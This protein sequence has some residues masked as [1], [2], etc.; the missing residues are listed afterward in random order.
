MAVGEHGLEDAQTR[1]GEPVGSENVIDSAIA[2]S[3][4]VPGPEK[5]APTSWM[6]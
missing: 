1:L 6:N 4:L 5:E 3:F 2:G